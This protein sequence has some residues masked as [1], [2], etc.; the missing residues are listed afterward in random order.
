MNQRQQALQCDGCDEWQHRTCNTG[1]SQQR[2]RDAV[3]TGDGI[4]WRCVGCTISDLVPVAE[5]TRVDNEDS[6]M[7]FLRLTPPGSSILEVRDDPEE[8]ATDD[9]ALG[10]TVDQPELE[11]ER[12]ISYEIPPQIEESSIE[13]PVILDNMIDLQPPSITYE[14]V[15]TCTKRGQKKLFD[16]RGYSYTIRQRRD[17]ATDWTCSI[18]GKNNCCPGSVIQR[19]DGFHTGVEHNHAGEVGLPAAAKLVKRKAEENLFRPASEIIDNVLLNEIPKS[20]CPTLLN[21]E[22]LIRPTNRLRQSKRPQDPKDLDFSL[23]EEH[24]PDDFFKADIRV[25]GRRH[26]IFAT[27]DQLSNLARAKGW[28][29][30]STFKLCRHPFSQLFTVNAFVRHDD[31]VKQVPLVFVLMSSRKKSDYIHVL[32]KLLE[33]IPAPK[34]QRVT[35]DF[36]RAIWR[37]FSKVMPN[38]EVKGCA[39]HWMQAVWRKVQGLGLQTATP[40]TRQ[41]TVIS[42]G[43]WPY[44]FFHMKPSQRCL[45]N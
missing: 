33:I 31:H 5:S 1:V 13:E 2:Y 28:Y 26:L 40:M 38:I 10:D 39:F 8:N 42:G 35:V 45:K 27:T 30:D 14:I 12:S 32:K 43:S 29:V 9:A 4:N 18:R 44:L 21:V 3:K 41:Q 15:D 11:S 16:S 7:S 19:A 20:A 17:T 34:V 22:H 24:I 6:V 36:E 37:A 25:R 23:K